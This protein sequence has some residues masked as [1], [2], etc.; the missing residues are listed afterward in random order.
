MEYCDY[1]V[2]NIF[3]FDQCSSVLAR[4]LVHILLALSWYQILAACNDV[5]SNIGRPLPPLHPLSKLFQRLQAP[6]PSAPSLTRK[7]VRSR[8]CTSLSQAR[9]VTRYCV[10]GPAN[11]P[12]C[13]SELVDLLN[14]EQ[15]ESHQ[16]LFDVSSCGFVSGFGD[17]WRM[18]CM[19]V[20]LCL[21]REGGVSGC[22][23]ERGSTLAYPIM[24]L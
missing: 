3:F 6:L 2:E 24:Q 19:C 1:I 21:L 5:K 20:C 10:Q 15:S 13:I 7:L 22:G 18:F 23:V 16:G 17:S 4:Y 9:Y 11:K 12:R 14:Q 8:L